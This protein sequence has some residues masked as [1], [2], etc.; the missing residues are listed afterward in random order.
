MPRV[1]LS[2]ALLILAPLA[3]EARWVRGGLHGAD[4]R[5]LVIHP[6]QPDTV[7][8]GTSQGEVYVSRDGGKSWENPRGA[9][10][11]PGHVVDNLSVDTRGR[12]WAACWGL[13]G[14]GVIAVSADEGI[15][16]SRRDAGLQEF[17]VRAL[18]NDPQDPRTIVAGGLTG[19]YRSTDDGRS[20]SKLSEHL[21]VES[22]AIDPRQSDRIYVGT[23][24]QAWRT[25]DG[26]KNWKHI[27]KGMVLD[28]DVFAI[29]IDSRNPDNVWLATCGWVY[30]SAD[31]GDN[32]IR[33]KDGF[34]N[35][36]IHA[37][38]YD[39]L[40]PLSIYAGSVAGLY[41]TVDGGKS[42]QCISDEDLV[43]NGIGIHPERPERIILGTEG[44]G[45][46][47]S[48]DRGRTF[49]RYNE[50]LYNVRVPAI[51]ADPVVKNRLYA[52]VMF[53]GAA[54][55]VYRSNDG[56]SNWDRLSTSKLPEVLSLIVQ[57][58]SSVKFI[59]G[60]EKGF[61]WSRDGRE[62]AQS[63]PLD[64]P[65]RVEKILQYNSM[66]LFAATAEG[67]FTSKDEGRSWYR[68]G[69]AK[70]KTIDIALGRLGEGRALY[71]L[72]SGGLDVF[73]G[74]SWRAVK[75]APKGG[76]SLAIRADRDVELVVIAGASGI[77]AGHI[78]FEGVW[79][80]SEAPKGAVAS[81]YQSSSFGR[82]VFVNLRDQSELLIGSVDRKGWRTLPLPMLSNQIATVAADPFRSQRVY[83]GTIGQGVF[84]W[85]ESEPPAVTHGAA[86]VGGGN[87]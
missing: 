65:L 23:W 35:R 39:P 10:P 79:H 20:W 16:W 59:A 83:L 76:Y 52:A 58:K 24:R 53:G 60:T 5:A 45:V 56:G 29:N 31:R 37:V 64:L 22:L 61:F 85:D 82:H 6:R 36:R 11:F 44:D 8:L 12:L 72:T 17:S 32:W 13:W 27:E 25:D 73:D 69:G 38:E 87:K 74:E 49:H 78:D 80:A 14:G 71:A 7:F 1:I 86:H 63:P 48:V 57:E 21:N 54:S 40:N 66:R 84:I 67:V 42:W 75:E 18:A 51:V 19:V 41:R 15:N 77:T 33:F 26:G 2:L 3:A 68:L 47:V 62:W 34:D 46:Y 9:V 55:G 70:D 50:G 28:T 81:V 30:S 43:I 4:V